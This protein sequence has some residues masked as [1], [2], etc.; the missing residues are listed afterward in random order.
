[1]IARY[2]WVTG[3]LSE[4]SFGAIGSAWPASG[5]DDPE[6]AEQGAYLFQPD[7]DENAYYCAESDLERAA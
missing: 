3:G 2:R 7:G 5:Y 4:P 1:M 6:S